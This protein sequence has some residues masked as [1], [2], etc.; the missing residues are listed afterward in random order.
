[1]VRCICC[2]YVHYDACSSFIPG[3]CYAASENSP[4]VWSICPPPRLCKLCLKYLLTHFLS[5]PLH[6]AFIALSLILTLP[7]PFLKLS[8]LFVCTC[9]CKARLIKHKCLDLT[10]ICTCTR[11]SAFGS[12]LIAQTLFIYAS[13]WVCTSIQLA[14]WVALS[15][16]CWRFEWPAVPKVK[17]HECEG[18]EGDSMETAGLLPST[19]NLPLSVMVVIFYGSG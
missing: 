13:V 14:C 2:K 9:E 1:M 8:L 11:L 17:G 16:R 18:S 19:N 5:S 4:A 15:I 6:S 12:D 10:L 7:F 3:W